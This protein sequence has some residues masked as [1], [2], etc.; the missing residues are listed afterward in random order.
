MMERPAV[1][2]LFALKYEV[3]DLVV[4]KS[5]LHVCKLFLSGS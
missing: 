3:I 2:L 1:H 4:L 5:R